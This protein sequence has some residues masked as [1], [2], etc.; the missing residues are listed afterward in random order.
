MASRKPIIACNSG[1][2]IETVEDGET[3]FLGYP[4]PVQFANAML[5]LAKDA[6]VAARMGEEAQKHLTN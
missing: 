3:G 4:S 6:G 2:L 5:K 1:G